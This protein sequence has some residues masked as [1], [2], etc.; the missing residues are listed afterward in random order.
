MPP[1]RRKFPIER[2]D[3][4]YWNFRDLLAYEK[5][6]SER[7]NRFFSVFGLAIAGL[8]AV[9][10]AA[11]IRAE[12]RTSDYA[13]ALPSWEASVQRVGILLPETDLVGAR[14]VRKRLLFLCSIKSERFELGL[15]VYPDDA[16][17]PEQLLS[18]AFAT[19][20]VFGAVGMTNAAFLPGGA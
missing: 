20:P 7:H 2:Q 15:A 8:H 14:T 5:E 12:L 11:E 1:C 10:M 17:T 6:R 13:L 16:T 9:D 19:D 4:R 3:C 18:R